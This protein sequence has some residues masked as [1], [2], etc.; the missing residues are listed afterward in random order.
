[1]LKHPEVVDNQIQE[2]PQDLEK[3]VL[4]RRRVRGFQLWG[5]PLT[6]RAQGL[7]EKVP[8]RTATSDSN[9]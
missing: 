1:M 8:E 3:Q 9:G 6:R 4:R 5:L 7:G 2:E